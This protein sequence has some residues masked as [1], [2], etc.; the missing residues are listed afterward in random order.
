M[1]IKRT[2]KKKIIIKIAISSILLI[3]TGL[4]LYPEIVEEAINPKLNQ[5]P[6]WPIYIIIILAIAYYLIR[7]IILLFSSKQPK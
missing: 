2:I 3:W 7:Q 1:S 4:I 6:G 5:K